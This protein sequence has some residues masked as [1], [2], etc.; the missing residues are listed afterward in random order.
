[1]KKMVFGDYHN[2][3]FRDNRDSNK[4]LRIS[5]E[6]YIGLKD[7]ANRYDALKEE[8][9]TL[10]KEN[11][12]LSQELDK[13]SKVTENVESFKE[14][15]EKYLNSLQRVQADFENYKKR[16]DKEK[17]NYRFYAVQRI[18]KKL[19][20]HYDDLKRAQKIIDVLDNESV[21]QGFR[22]IVKNFEKLLAEEGVKAMECKGEKFD[23]YKH[24][25]LLVQEDNNLPNNTILEE[26]DK[27][28]YYNDK[29][30]RPA[31][32]SVSKQSN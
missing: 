31:R 13:L 16:I 28:Y 14:K 7:K 26:L 32:V 21:K 23:P 1:M 20:S 6:E 4:N 18:L 8:I 3:F 25:A 12:K 19:V 24:D 2:G 11:K 9:N 30:L 29:V 27:G 15:S 22:M 5:K 10:Q 17:E